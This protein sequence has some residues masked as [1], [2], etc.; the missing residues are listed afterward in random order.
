MVSHIKLWWP[1]EAKKLIFGYCDSI[2]FMMLRLCDN[3]VFLYG[4]FRQ[5]ICSQT[6]RP[7]KTLS[8]DKAS[9]LRLVSFTKD[10]MGCLALR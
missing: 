4:E 6:L 8:S 2:G 3:C 9:K 1:Y 10:D 5:K 7:H